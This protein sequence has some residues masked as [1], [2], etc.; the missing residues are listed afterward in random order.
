MSF[1][2]IKLD[3][4]GPVARVILNR[5]SSLNSLNAQAIVELQQVLDGLQNNPQVRVLVL[6]GAGKAF[7]AGQDLSDPAMHEI[8]GKRP[9]VGAVVERYY[10]PL[11]LR[12]QALNVP[13]IAAVNGLAA[14]G[15]ASIALA[16]DLV[17]AARSAYFLQ[18]FSRI[19]LTPDT[20]SSW[21]LAHKI[22]T[23]RAI[24]LTFLADKLHAAK[25]AD[26]GLIWE[27]YDDAEFASAVEQLAGRVAAMPTK[28][29]VRTREL[30]AAARAHT[31][32]Q[33]L[34]M[35]VSFVR[36]MGWSADY[37]EGVRAFIDKRTPSFQGK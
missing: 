32:E 13:T 19:G 27:V 34:S 18:A 12:L 21:F 25:A 22:G 37:L 5:P 26:W 24:G 15:G 30:V 31:L 9:D 1:S 4:Q 10:K 20:G 11:V 6:T 7:C 35:E 16:C 23:A 17:V 29:L 36:E 33:Q 3:I 14:G 2:N 8:E 28:A